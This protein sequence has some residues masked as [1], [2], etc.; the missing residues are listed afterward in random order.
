MIIKEL[1]LDNFGVYAGRQVF[2]LEPPCP[3]HP[4][5]LIGGLN[6]GGKTT[7]LDAVQLALY[8]N[9][10]RCSAREK[11]SYKEFLRKSINRNT[12]T[13]KAG[14]EMEF[15][16]HFAGDPTTLRICRNW[17]NN[18]KGVEENLSI[19]RD[20]ELDNLLTHSWSNRVEEYLPLNIAKLFFFDGERIE[21]LADSD[22]SRVLMETG[23]DSL[24][25]VDIIRQLDSDLV[26]LLRHKLKNKREGKDEKELEAVESSIQKLETLRQEALHDKAQNQALYEQAVA[27]LESANEKYN[28]EGGDLYEQRIAIEQKRDKLRQ[29]IVDKEEHL[30]DLA[31]GPLPFALVKDLFQNTLEHSVLE[32]NTAVQQKVY[33]QMKIRNKNIM[34]W[35]EKQEF[36]EDIQK[37]IAL[38]LE[39][40]ISP[41]KD[42]VRWRLDLGVNTTEN[43]KMLRDRYLSDDMG[44][45]KVLMEVVEK[46]DLDYTE[47]ERLL[48]TIPEEA[49]IRPLL[50]ERERLRSRVE[51]LTVDLNT[52]T[53]IFERVDRELISQ[54]DSLV[55]LLDAQ[56]RE[57][58]ERDESER[59]VIHAKR[60]RKT[61]KQFRMAVIREHIGRIEE[62]V[63]SC[64]RRLLHKELLIEKVCLDVSSFVI[65]IKGFDGESIPVEQLSAGERQLLAV[66]FLWG[67]ANVS[68][69]ALPTIIDT[70]LGRLDSLHRDRLINNYFPNASHQVL[71]LSTDEEID[72]D[73]Y[74]ILRPYVGH[75]YRLVFDDSIQAT[76]VV[77]GYFWAK[78]LSY[79]D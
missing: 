74:K 48:S 41:P 47:T 1:V 18:G 14:V 62:E 10:A 70:P 78:E 16:T 15:E 17:A 53:E 55:R 75:E 65:T 72:R 39:S 37:S 61:L 60:V 33:E 76:T 42:K 22:R 45:T 29:E 11:Y 73:L 34:E 26:V 40:T 36:A 13:M 38:F 66:S 56:V 50:S 9:R 69:R 59:I 68:G 67:L 19:W 8:G 28:R 25:G 35:I 20:G 43:M 71:L 63:T 32:Q 27:K 44:K 52:S 4:V 46:L 24:L 64:F 12:N 51:D 7:I 21:G 6:G 23:I 5:I 79:A 30:R 58:L 2:D 31:M 49:R 57:L 77:P 54:K 3:D